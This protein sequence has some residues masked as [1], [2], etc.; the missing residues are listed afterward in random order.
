MFRLRQNCSVELGAGAEP[1]ALRA[2]CRA[3]SRVV[4]PH[5]LAACPLRYQCAIIALAAFLWPAAAHAILPATDAFDRANGALGANWTDTSAGTAYTISAQHAVLAGTPGPGGLLVATGWNADTVG[6][7][8]YAQADVTLSNGNDGSRVGVACRVA[9]IDSYY[10]YIVSG[11]VRYFY[12]KVVGALTIF[13]S[14]VE[15]CSTG[16][17]CSV[18]IKIEC[19]GTHVR[20]YRNGIEDTAVGSSSSF[21]DASLTTGYPGLA[22]AQLVDQVNTLDNWS[23]DS[24][25]GATPTP[26]AVGTATNTP[27]PT[28]TPISVCDTF[29]R[30]ALGGNWVDT[31]AGAAFETLF[32]AAAVAGASNPTL[33]V[34]A[35]WTADLFSGNHQSQATINSMA[36]GSDESRVGVACRL[37]ADGSD[38]YYGYVLSGALRVFY[39]KVNGSFALLGT[40]IVTDGAAHTGDQV[41]I[42]CVGSTIHAYLNG[43]DDTAVGSPAVDTSIGPSGAPGLAGVRF[44]SSNGANR[45]DDWCGANVGAATTP[46]PSLSI[47]SPATYTVLQRD[48]A[49][50]ADI[51]IAGGVIGTGAIEASWNSGAW[52]TI[53]TAAGATTYSGML[54]AQP[55]G[56]GTLTV[57]FVDT[58]AVS[59]SRVLVGIGDVYA[60]AGQSN[61]AGYGSV[62][63][64]Y[65][66]TSLVASLFGNDYVWKELADPVDNSVG[67]IDQ[68][69]VDTVCIP[70][71]FHC[72]SGWPKLATLLMAAE[73]VPVAFVPAAKGSTSITQWQPGANHDDRTTLYGSLHHRIQTVGGVKAVLFWQG[74]TDAINGMAQDTYQNLVT[75]LA[76]ALATD[77][78]GV[79]LALASV[80]EHTGASAAGLSAIRLAQ[81]AAWDSGNPAIVPGPTLY[82]EPIS[83]ADGT[84]WS[85]DAEWQV[86]AN[87]WFAAL[88]RNFY[89]GPD[90]RGPR[91]LRVEYNALKTQLALKFFDESFP[92]IPTSGLSGFTVRDNGTVKAL[93]GSVA[94]ANVVTLVL[95]AAATSGFITVSIAEGRTGT[96]AVVPRDSSTY[97]LPA[98]VV[99]NALAVPAPTPFQCAP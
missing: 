41:A 38:T 84:H 8:Q 93:A 5:A 40:G 14:K 88:D 97:T 26:G 48:D 23:A 28:A 54:S 35:R 63:Q 34:A 1:A 74:E 86:A 71:P 64:F 10:G 77:F 80:G 6:A 59:A 43:V 98:D 58:P 15:N 9:A 51:A 66:S 67:Q 17:Q 75:A 73:G 50:V 83:G 53:A 61:A 13:G 56:Q 30:S 96:G 31:A 90:G 99:V 37:A 55:A 81:Q 2:S 47:T 36:A 20:V 68:V 94:G 70:S 44:A 32:N 57:R 12:K 60:V 85:T 11:T 92:I 3:A 39:K 25:P 69:S 49:D 76:N 52:Q 72:G 46:T 27:V 45:L 33:I 87:R 89:G 82:D 62:Q 95:A 21:T 22:G 65:T 18:T 16:S 78:P 4:L 29:N 42:S 7:D 19:S 79:T 91:L 24:I